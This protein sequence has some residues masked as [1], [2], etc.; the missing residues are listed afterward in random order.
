MTVFFNVTDAIGSGSHHGITRVERKLASALAGQPDVVFVVVHRGALWRIGTGDVLE[1]LGGP[2][3]DL[4]PTVERLGVDPPIDAS[5]RQHI[6]QLMLGLRSKQTPLVTGTTL[7]PLEAERDDVLVSA[8]VDWTRGFL[9]AVE[10]EV[11]GIGV[12]YV[13]FC[14][15]LIPVD[16]PEWIFP[17][18]RDR[19]LRHFAR[20]A[21][22]ASSIV[23]IS[24]CTRTD[25]A[26]HFPSYRADRLDVLAL[27][28]DAA[29]VVGDEE[30]SFARSIFDGQ[31]YAVYCATLDRRK[32]HQILYRA[33]RE[34]TRGDINLRLVFV[35]MLGSGV[36]DLLNTIRNDPMVRG[37][38]AHVSNCDDRQLAALYRNARFA[39]YPSLYEG[40][41]LGVTEALAHGKRCVVASGSSLREAS[42]GTAVEVHPLATQEW[43]DAMSGLLQ[44]AGD[45][46]I[47]RLPTWDESATQLLELVQR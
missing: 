14:Y 43:V 13:G 21:R 6:K 16:H 34:M 28:S 35:G 18:E 31:P 45:V 5:R 23:C 11:F 40:W 30:M 10:R 32:N 24:E 9:E 25:F 22:T 47:P 36:S 20:M 2:P 15:D 27:G 41:G 38:I 7:L 1:S 44:D 4:R 39:V 17:P 12:R 29:L 26:R 42:F 46:D 37:R 19:F 8:G 33:M 3:A